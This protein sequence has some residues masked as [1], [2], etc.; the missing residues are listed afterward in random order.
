MEIVVV[1]LGLLLTVISATKKN[2]K[3]DGKSPARAKKGAPSPAFDE[4]KGVVNR[5]VASVQPA[6]SAGNAAPTEGG[7]LLEDDECAG[8]SMPH[9]HT[10]G[11]SMLED[12]LCAGGSM[13]HEHTEGLGAPAADDDCLGGSMAHAHNEGANRSEVHQRMARLDSKREADEKDAHEPLIS[14]ADIDM[15]AMRRAVIM[16]EVLGRPRAMRARR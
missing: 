3:K 13:P 7:Q 12:P 15:K 16:A 9:E 6:M 2:S 11:R 10:Q 8:G 5:P 14:A 4:T 1:L